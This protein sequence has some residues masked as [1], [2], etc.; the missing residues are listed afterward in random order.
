MIINSHTFGR[1]FSDL[2]AV[3]CEVWRTFAIKFW[4]Q[5][6][7]LL[8]SS[9]DT[10]CQ[11]LIA[12]VLHTSHPLSKITEPPA[13]GVR[14]NYHSS[15]LWSMGVKIQISLYISPSSG[16]FFISPD[17][18]LLFEVETSRVN[19]LVSFNSDDQRNTDV[20]T[21]ADVT[22]YK[23]KSSRWT[24]SIKPM[25]GRKVLHPNGWKGQAH[26]Q[27]K[28]EQYPEFIQCKHVQYHE[29]HYPVRANAPVRERNEHCIQMNQTQHFREDKHI[30]L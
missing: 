17:E 19:F 13:K 30:N 22:T 4:H 9:S 24:F 8:Q 29:E 18:D 26:F 21:T 11:N 2:W 28:D 1:R 23:S 5:V 3:G 20:A 27:Y 6:S 7:E 25:K 14:I 16:L 10:R 12:K 15:V